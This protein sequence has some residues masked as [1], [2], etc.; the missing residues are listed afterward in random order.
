[1]LSLASLIALVDIFGILI[2]KSLG[3]I[4]LYGDGGERM[5]KAVVDV[6]GYPRP[7]LQGY[8]A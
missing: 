6:A 1:M 7:L 5:S 2:E 4:E 8:H 3:F